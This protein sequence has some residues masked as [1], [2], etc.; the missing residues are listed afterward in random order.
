[1]E[2]IKLIQGNLDRADEILKTLKEW[3]GW[4]KNNLNCGNEFN[5]YYVDSFGD[6]NYMYYPEG[7]K[8]I[9]D[10]KAELFELLDLD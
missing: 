10:G 6:I 4:N 3:G 7:D 8:Y 1:M 9:A 5:Y 2:K